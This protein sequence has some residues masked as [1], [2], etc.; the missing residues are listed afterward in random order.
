MTGYGKTVMWIGL[1]LILLN[2]IRY[3]TTIRSTLFGSN[4]TVSATDLPVFPFGGE[5]P[6]LPF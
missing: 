6:D 4:K 2:T 5:L 1:I 3:W